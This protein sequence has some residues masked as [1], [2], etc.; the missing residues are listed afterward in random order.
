MFRK[1]FTFSF[2]FFAGI[3][4]FA[5]EKPVVRLITDISGI[6]DKSYNASC[7]NGI[8]EYY[9][10]NISHPKYKG[11]LYD[12]VSCEEN[13]TYEK[14]L[15]EQAQDETVDLII[16]CGIQF[17]ESV[18]KV[19][20]NFPE[21]KFVLIDSVIN[22]SENVMCFTFNEE[23]GSYL[24]GLACALEAKEEK[25]LKPVFGFIGGIKNPA[26]T[27]FEMGYIQ[28]IKSVIPDAQIVEFYAD[29]FEKPE[30][31]REQSEAWYKSGVYAIFTAAGKTGLGTI[32][33]SKELRLK[34]KK[35]WAVGVD[36]DQYY[37]GL[38]TSTKSSVLTSMIKNTGNACKIAIAAVENGKFEGKK[39]NLS[40]ED[41][42]VDYS[43]K[44]PA[45][46]SSV[47]HSVDKAR[48]DII[49]K[50]IFVYSTYKE[51]KEHQIAPEGLSAID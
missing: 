4:C 41:K 33:L 48:N 23:Q 44:N 5:K 43:K 35:V 11:I 8:V 40:L 26:I 7:W 14:T 51:A 10:D 22:D 31:A 6:D 39:I 13:S 18:A 36:S 37:E 28:G 9:E 20:K 12:F 24:V 30:L 25:I 47:L 1:I 32:F 42:G 21:K 34:G 29:S 17:K 19:S 15:T 50:K 49:A 27:K 16:V 2:L 3:F 38:Y 46:K 45:L